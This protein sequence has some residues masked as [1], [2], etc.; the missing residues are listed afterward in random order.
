M[1]NPALQQRG[2][3]VRVIAF[4][5]TAHSVWGVVALADTTT[6]E[7]RQAFAEAGALAWICFDSDPNLLE[8]C[9]YTD[10]AGFRVHRRCIRGEKLGVL[11]N[12]CQLFLVHEATVLSRAGGDFDSRDFGPDFATG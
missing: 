1:D 5:G 4:D 3:M 2:Q 7:S 8:F 9:E 10:L 11:W 12:T 6:G